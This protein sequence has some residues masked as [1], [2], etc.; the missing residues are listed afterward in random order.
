MS[1]R[2]PFPRSVFGYMLV[3]VGM[4]VVTPILVSAAIIVLRPPPRDPPLST[5]EVARLL[6]G[7]RIVER[8]RDLP[9]STVAGLPARTPAS[10]LETILSRALARQAGVAEGAAIV[11]LEDGSRHGDDNSWRGHLAE[12]EALYARSGRFDP[13]IFGSFTAAVRQADGSWKQMAN[14]R[15]DA[16]S[17]WQRATLIWF[18]VSA[19]VLLPLAWLLSSRLV[20]PLRAITRAA[21]RIGRREQVEPLLPRGPDEARQAAMALNDM[22][23]RLGRYVAERTS[24]AGAIAHDLR[25]PLSR[26]SFHLADAPEP[27]ATRAMAEVAEMEAM[28]RA[29]L[30]FVHDEGRAPERERIDLS[31]LLESLADDRRD[32]GQDVDFAG[33]PGMVVAGDQVALRRAFDNLVNNALAY[34]GQARLRIAAAGDACRVTV[35]DDGPGLPPQEL[36]RVMEPYY[37]AESSRSRATGGIGLGLAIV[38]AVI[39]NHGGGVRL[40]NGEKG[41]LEAVVLLPLT[42]ARTTGMT[43]LFGG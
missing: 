14:R 35:A 34:G 40:T 43:A 3:L 16:L 11:R 12:E 20:L 36:E 38:R 23:D 13:V 25:T 33:Q 6:R 41:G 15:D 18:G 24:M 10:P 5:Y 17:R 21:E 30:D 7:E 39:E 8:R 29:T 9:V 26:L 2:R 42:G 31:L 27:M 32:L 19:L 37:R 4:S 28:I 1:W 22:Q